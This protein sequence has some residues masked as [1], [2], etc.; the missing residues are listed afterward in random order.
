MDDNAFETALAEELPLVHQALRRRFPESGIQPAEIAAAARR[1]SRVGMERDTFFSWLYGLA[2]RRHVIQ[3]VAGVQDDVR[4]A[5]ASKCRELRID[6]EE[7]V[8][9][10]W[11]RAQ[12]A[13]EK[14][15]EDTL[16]QFSRNDAFRWLYTLA[17]HAAHDI[18]RKLNVRK[19]GELPPEFTDAG[20]AFDSSI[21]V[22]ECIR[23]LPD[24]E[25]LA[26]DLTLKGYTPTE[27]ADQLRQTMKKVY[28]WIRRA[29]LL[30][31]VCLGEGTEGQPSS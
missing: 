28:H 11:V 6:G 30:L 29:R 10:A 24:E 15:G 25:R 13:I 22:H 27:I 5:L 1:Q 8:Q 19:A 18:R 17:A 20:S 26:I 12:P 31:K 2:F 3:L 21:D 23:R 14:N 16:R 7:A 9:D 4:A